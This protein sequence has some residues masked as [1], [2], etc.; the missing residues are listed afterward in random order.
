V[1]IRCYKYIAPKGAKT[2]D[3]SQICWQTLIISKTIFLCSGFVGVFPLSIIMRG[4]PGVYPPPLLK[5]E[6][7]PGGEV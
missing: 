2:T 7:G 5:K 4:G 3:L 6:R 1:V